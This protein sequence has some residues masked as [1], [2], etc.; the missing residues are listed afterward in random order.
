[1]ARPGGLL[2]FLLAVGVVLGVD[3]ARAPKNVSLLNLFHVKE[4]SKFWDNDILLKGKHWTSRPWIRDWR[5]PAKF[6]HGS[7][8]VDRYVKA[9]SVASYLGLSQVDSLYLPIP[10]NFVFVGFSGE[11]NHGLRLG[12]EELLHWF[13]HI[14]HILEHTRVPAAHAHG[15]DYSL[16]YDYLLPMN[17]Y[18]RYNYSVHAIEMGQKVSRIFEDAIRV[19]SRLEDPKDTRADEAAVWQVDIESLARI[20]NNLCKHLDIENVYNIFVF[21]PN[22]ER[23]RRHYGYRIRLHL[24]GNNF[25]L[26]L[27]FLDEDRRKELLSPDLKPVP[28]LLDVVQEKMPLYDRRPAHKFHWRPLELHEAKAWVNTYEQLLKFENN[29]NRHNDTHD[30]A[31]LKARQ[32]IKGQ[33]LEMSASLRRALQEGNQSHWQP[34]CLSDTYVGGERWALIDLTAGPFTWGPRVGGQGFRTEDTLPNVEKYFREHKGGQGVGDDDLEK[35]LETMAEERFRHVEESQGHEVEM[36]LAELDIYELFARKHCRDRARSVPLCEELQERVESMRDELESYVDSVSM[37]KSSYAM[38]GLA[39]LDN[40]QSMVAGDHSAKVNVSRAWDMFLA[41]VGAVLSSAMRHIITPSLMDGEYHL[42]DRVNFHLY[43]ISRQVNELASLSLPQATPRCH[44]TSRPSPGKSGSWLSQIRNL[45]SLLTGR[46]SIADDPAIAMAYAGAL[47]TSV[48]LVPSHNGTLVHTRRNYLDSKL[49]QHQLEHELDLLDGSLSH[50]T[51]PAFAGKKTRSDH[52]IREVPIFIF[53]LKGPPLF[54]DESLVAKS[55]HNMVVAVLSEDAAWQSP[56][57]CNNIP[58][59]WNLKRPMKALV[60]ATALHLA[61]LVPRQLSYS[62]EHASTSQSWLWSV[63]PHA[64]SATAAGHLLSQFELDTVPRSYIVTALDN[65]VEDVNAAVAML[66]REDTHA[67]TF[68][69]FK[70]MGEQPLVLMYDEVVDL[71]EKIGIMVGE[72]NYGEAS[73][74]L[75]FLRTSS[76]SFRREAEAVV[77]ALHPAR[78]VQQRKLHLSVGSSLAFVSIPAAMIILIRMRP[79]RFKPKI[80]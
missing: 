9:G 66:S 38:A 24:Q 41:E 40:W 36:L 21:N 5:K 64:T 3:A 51:R 47:R 16:H 74:M 7:H 56:L 52:D 32:I 70:R 8:E 26:S 57:S 65:S 19:L 17:T 35:E 4:G 15:D 58:I 61:G 50:A 25:A 31:H 12:E 54:I 11:G 1:M 46:L 53:A 68:R 23:A 2:A 20:I 34:D 37:S 42:Y 75:Y 63:G 67:S 49:L 28:E 55:L 18:V 62:H 79:K 39:R 10:I 44:L 77:A 76:F 6:Y 14:D 59:L 13:E 22:P 80:N 29:I 30:N 48:V 45:S 69:A 73:K 78:C 71:W 27:M 72:L 60:A 33:N 43:L